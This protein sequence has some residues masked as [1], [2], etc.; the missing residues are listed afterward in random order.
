M[1]IIFA[2]G[3]TAGTRCLEY[4]V[5]QNEDIVGVLAKD[6]RKDSRWYDSPFIY[7]QEH[8]L[9]IIQ[10]HTKIEADVLFSVFYHRLI[11]KTMLDSVA[12]SINF[13][14]GKLPQ[15]KGCNTNMWVIIN[16]ETETAATAHIMEEQFDNG[17]IVGEKRV[18]VHPWSTGRSVYDDTT[19]ATIALFKEIYNQVKE[20]TITRTPQKPGGVYYT[21][22]LPNNGLISAYMTP[23]RLDRYIRALH[24]PPFPPPKVSGVRR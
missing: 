14:G 15:Y 1:K 23:E 13:H 22:T 18:R 21:K 20:G 5:E 17:D 19:I 8:K 6:D 7:A 3:K 24:F 2:A 10:P 11:P 16:E 12:L 4:L 9:P